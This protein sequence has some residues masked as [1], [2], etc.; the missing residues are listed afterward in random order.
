MQ[1]LDGVGT[2]EEGLFQTLTK[3]LKY[4]VA[5]SDFEK[6]SRAIATKKER[7]VLRAVS[8]ILNKDLDNILAVN[9]FGF[10][11]TCKA[12]AGAWGH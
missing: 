3:S 1:I 8:S 12:I 4:G 6:L 11:L 2:V 5:K 7:A 9:S 10:L